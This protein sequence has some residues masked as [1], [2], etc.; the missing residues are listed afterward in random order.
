M[1]GRLKSLLRRPAGP[2]PDLG[3]SPCGGPQDA[4]VTLAAVCGKRFDIHRPDAASTFRLGLCRGF[5]RIGLSYRLVSVFEVAKVLPSLRNPVVCL[6]LFEYYDMSRRSLKVLSRYP[7]FVWMRPNLSA[8]RQV[9]APY[10]IHYEEVPADVIARVLESGPTFA[11]APVPP[12][13]L[14]YYDDWEKRGLRLL[15]IPQACDVDRYFPE[16][17][18]TRYSDVQMAFVGGYWAKKAIQFDRYLKPYEDILQ[19]YGYSR[20][21]Y[22]GYRGPLPE[23]EERTLYQNARLCPAISEPHAE[24]V[25]DIVERVYKIMGSGGLAVT[26]VTPSYAELFSRDELLYPGSLD[27]YHDVVREALRDEDLC[28]RYRKAGYEAVMARHTYAH[29]ARQI[30]D[31]LGMGEL[32]KQSRG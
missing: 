2:R 14:P 27:E 12:S 31:E 17:S 21:P 11:W 20:W 8:L 9:Y 4:P 3:E 25:G 16:P 23:D 15:S 24:L 6:S 28:H 10:G 5:A 19:V 26:D 30:L 13:C 29:R 32:G 7:H 1:L 18:N 22:R